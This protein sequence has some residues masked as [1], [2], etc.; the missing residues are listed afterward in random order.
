M[1]VADG[2]S[3]GFRGRYEID[4]DFSWTGMDWH[5]SVRKREPV[6]LLLRS[7]FVVFPLLT[8]RS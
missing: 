2:G 7:P 1:G 5:L 4:V 3:S 8:L 6:G